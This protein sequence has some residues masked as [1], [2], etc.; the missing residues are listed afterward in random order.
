MVNPFATVVLQGRCHT[1]RRP[2]PIQI[3]NDLT[4]GGVNSAECCGL[5]AANSTG[6]SVRYAR[7]TRKSRRG[8]SAQI[9]ESQS[10]GQVVRTAVRCSLRISRPALERPGDVTRV[11]RGNVPQHRDE[12]TDYPRNLVVSHLQ[13]GDRPVEPCRRDCFDLFARITRS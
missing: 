8:Q 4:P 3:I 6:W 5:Q 10:P 7:L 2:L 12:R 9:L 11:H 13:D 1:D